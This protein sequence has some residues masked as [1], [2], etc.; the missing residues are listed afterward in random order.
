MR[1]LKDQHVARLRQLDES[2]EDLTRKLAIHESIV[3]LSKYIDWKSLEKE[4]ESHRDG[5]V[6]R[7][8]AMEFN[9]PLDKFDRKRD[10]L[11]T[12]AKVYEFLIRAPLRSEI[13]KAEIVGNLA[14]LDEEISRLEQKTGQKGNAR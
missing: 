13:Q 14:R 4:M 9:G 1:S 3:R 10:R 12:E 2:K 6:R 8:M 11:L 5:L 7:A